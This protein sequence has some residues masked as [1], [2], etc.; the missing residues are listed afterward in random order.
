MLPGYYELLTYHSE[1]ERLSDLSPTERAMF[2]G[3][4]ADLGEAVERCCKVADSAF[5]RVNLEILGNTDAYLHAHIWPRYE[6]E[7]PELM[8]QTVWLYPKERWQDEATALGH[9]HEALRIAITKYLN[10]N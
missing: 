9:E 1:A 4:M 7:P 10:G 5:R 6:W 3:S 8:H 2:L